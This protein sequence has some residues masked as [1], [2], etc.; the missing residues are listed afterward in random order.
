MYV[1][2]Y[3]IFVVGMSV[4]IAGMFG[5]SYLSSRDEPLESEPELPQP[6]VVPRDTAHES[7]FTVVDESVAEAETDLISDTAVVDVAALLQRIEDAESRIEA[8]ETELTEVRLQQ[9]FPEDSATEAQQEELLSSVF[10]PT[11]VAD[12]QSIRDNFQLQRLE[13]RDRAIRE[14]WIN[15]DRFREESRALRSA[16]QLR[17]ALG[18]EGYDKL[19]VAEG[20]DN[21]VRIESVIENSAADVSGIEVGDVIIR[22]ADD[23]IFQFRDLRDGTTGGER[24]ETV[25]IQVSRDGELIDLV[26]PRG[27]MGVTLTGVTQEPLP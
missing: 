18:D 7:P 15:T 23:R 9:F 20:R 25:I 4:A 6:G 22:Y 12:I 2:K 11:T 1:G 24:N 5:F 17:E 26:I 21:R 8:L 19:L 16:G 10:E 3:L 27:P 13:L 14:G